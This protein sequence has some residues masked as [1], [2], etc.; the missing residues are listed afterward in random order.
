MVWVNNSRNQNLSVQIYDRLQKQ[1]NDSYVSGKNNGY[2][3]RRAIT[4]YQSCKTNFEFFLL[5]I[6]WHLMP[7]ILKIINYPL[8]VNRMGQQFFDVSYFFFCSF[9]LINQIWKKPWTVEKVEAGNNL[10]RLWTDHARTQSLLSCLI[11]HA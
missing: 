7:C 4:R 3:N 10:L 11:V 8:S 1:T 6:L 9:R 5:F 2:E